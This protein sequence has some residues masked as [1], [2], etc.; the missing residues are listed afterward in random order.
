MADEHGHKT[1]SWIVVGLITVAFIVL[2]FAFVM[3]SL[4][5]A[6]VGG[7]F[8]VAG[9]VTGGVTGIMDDAY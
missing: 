4:P 2:G 6:I 9:A 8:G 3:Q 5:L 1:S 7:V